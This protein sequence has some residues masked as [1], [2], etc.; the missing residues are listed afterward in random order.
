MRTNASYNPLKEE[1]T[2]REKVRNIRWGSKKNSKIYAN[3][4][5]QTLLDYKWENNGLHLKV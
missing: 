1:N 3:N 4:I 2:D 5:I